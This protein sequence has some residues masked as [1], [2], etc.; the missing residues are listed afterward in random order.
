MAKLNSQ[1]P[2]GTESFQWLIR[3]VIYLLT[4]VS[5]FR[6]VRQKMEF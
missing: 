2:T 5:A 4:L 6:G 1:H 3:T